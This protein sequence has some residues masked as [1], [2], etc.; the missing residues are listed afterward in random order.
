MKKIIK[1]IL[2]AISIMLT[3]TDALRAIDSAAAVNIM[4]DPNV[5]P[6]I[7]KAVEQVQDEKFTQEELALI[8]EFDQYREYAIKITAEQPTY[9]KNRVFWAGFI[10]ASLGGIAALTVSMYYLERLQEGKNKESFSKFLTSFS[11]IM[12]ECE[13]ATAGFILSGAAVGC[14]T[15][16][17]IVDYIHQKVQSKVLRKS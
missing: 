1:N 13:G 5:K 6:L 10:P 2:I 9:F 11:D 17:K 7:A 4:S 16:F 12:C 3:A 15:Y 8:D 14:V